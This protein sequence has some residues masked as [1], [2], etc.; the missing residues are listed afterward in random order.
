MRF[1]PWAWGLFLFGAAGLMACGSDSGADDAATDERESGASTEPHFELEGR[2]ESPN[3]S[4]V[5]DVIEGE[6]ASRLAITSTDAAANVTAIYATFHGL[7]T[8]VGSHVFP[9]QTVVDDEAFAVSSLDGWVYQSSG[10][11]LRMS[12]TSDHHSEGEFELTLS[13]DETSPAPPGGATP[14]AE[15][16]L[17]GSFA[18]E[19]RV[20]CRSYIPGFTG[21]HAVSDSPFCQA[22]TF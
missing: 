10:G 6:E 12:I 2:G 15:L 16:T 14:P 7:E 18:S 11:E 1:D 19:W 8:V 9:V 4:A 17:V 20:N 5:L 13:L 22:L 21:G 3:L